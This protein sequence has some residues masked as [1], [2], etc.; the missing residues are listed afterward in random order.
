MTLRGKAA[1]AL[2]E[3]GEE[4]CNRAVAQLKNFRRQILLARSAPPYAKLLDPGDCSGLAFAVNPSHTHCKTT[5]MTLDDRTGVGETLYRLDEFVTMP[6]LDGIEVKRVGMAHIAFRNQIGEDQYLVAWPATLAGR[7]H[8][9]GRRDA[10]SGAQ[11]S[12][13]A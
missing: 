6:R 3:A 8:R 1:I 4:Q 5:S 10:P 2:P 11:L 13:L 9:T 12:K 7:R